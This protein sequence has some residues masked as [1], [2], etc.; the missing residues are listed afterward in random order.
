MQNNKFDINEWDFYEGFDSLDF[1]F[2]RVNN[3]ID[4]IFDTVSE[5]ELCVAFNTLGFLKYKVTYPLVKSPYLLAPGGIYIKKINSNTNSN[6]NIFH[7]GQFGNAFFLGMMLHFI[8][9]KNNLKSKYKYFNEFKK[10]GIDF[11]TEGEHFHTDTLELSDDIFFEY[12]SEKSLEKSNI[13]IGENMWAQTTNFSIYLRNYIN[14][15]LQKNK[16]IYNNEFYSRY[17]RNNDLCVHV[18]LGD[19]SNIY[20]QSFEYYDKIISK[21]TFDT[22]YI[23]SDSINNKI[24]IDLSQKYNLIPIN[25]DIV[26]IIMFASSCKNIVLSQGTFSWLIGLLGF[27][28]TIYY[29][30]ITKKWHGDIFVFDDWIEID[31]EI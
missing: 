14:N 9:L 6:T 11:F 8:S 13:F 10:L 1:D 19:V 15:D 31:T 3:S 18:R 26:K 4:N 2:K 7:P 17:N 5:H 29:P 21:I 30:K 23:I 27:F 20:S 12:I 25:Y 22:G 28:S 16:I 24:C